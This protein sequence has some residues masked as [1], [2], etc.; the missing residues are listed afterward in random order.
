MSLQ[1]HEPKKGRD[2]PEGVPSLDQICLE[3]IEEYGLQRR[4]EFQLST[5]SVLG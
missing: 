5:R 4:K 2:A 3:M 1:A